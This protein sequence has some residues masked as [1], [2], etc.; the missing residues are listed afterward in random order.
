MD[1]SRRDVECEEAHRPHHQ[2]NNEEYEK[3]GSS[4]RRYYEQS[5]GHECPSLAK[6]P[7]VCLNIQMGPLK[8]SRC[9]MLLLMPWMIVLAQAPTGEIAGRVY[10]P[11]GG[12][13]P[14]ATISV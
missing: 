8:V 7:A 9:T 1:E 5:K 2:Q 12:A 6:R 3:H 4:F 13:V 11:S 10:D 14:N